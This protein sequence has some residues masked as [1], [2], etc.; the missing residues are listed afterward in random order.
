[1]L[2][3]QKFKSHKQKGNYLISVTEKKKKEN[4]TRLNEIIEKQI[5]I[6]INFYVFFIAIQTQD[7]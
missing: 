3:L 2:L 7:N 4:E 6:L 1:M 5:I